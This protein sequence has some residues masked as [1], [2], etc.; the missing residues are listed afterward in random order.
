MYCQVHNDS[1]KN[2][3][4]MTLLNTYLQSIKLALLLPVNDLFPKNFK[5]FVIKAVLVMNCLATKLD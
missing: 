3:Y 5:N 2:T 1:S 4:Y